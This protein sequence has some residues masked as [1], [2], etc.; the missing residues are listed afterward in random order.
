[1]KSIK[2]FLLA[3]LAGMAIS[4]GGIVFLSSESKVVGAIFF[5]IG[6]FTV[7][8]FGLNLFTGKVCYAL[9]NKASYILDLVLIWLGNF[10]GSL[11]CGFAMRATRFGDTLTQ[12]AVAICEKKLAGSPLSTIVLGIFCNICIFIAVDGY[13]KNPHEIGKY[14]ALLFGVTVFIL[15]GF[16]HCV[17]NMFYFSVAGILNAKMLIFLL[18]NTLGN[19]IG[20]LLFPLIFK[21]TKQ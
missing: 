17:A 1:M 6:L 20:G 11:L 19:V 21:I 18:Q 10:A 13:K 5:T 7:C 9:E 12:T 4:I 15:S 3:V 16:E 8:T 14:L 2:T